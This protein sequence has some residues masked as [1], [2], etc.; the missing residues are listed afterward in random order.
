[1]A[2]RSHRHAGLVPD[3]P[4]L[5]ESSRKAISFR[6]ISHWMQCC[7]ALP[8]PLFRS[9]CAFS[10]SRSLSLSFYLTLSIFLFVTCSRTI[11]IMNLF[12]CQYQRN[13]STKFSH[14]RINFILAKSQFVNLNLSLSLSSSYLSFF[15]KNAVIHFRRHWLHDYLWAR[16]GEFYHWSLSEGARWERPVQVQRRRRLKR[17]GWRRLEV[18]NGMAQLS[19]VGR[20]DEVVV[21]RLWKVAVIS[22]RAHRVLQLFYE[23]SNSQTWNREST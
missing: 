14:S 10:R 20:R 1:M 3:Y 5:R 9:Q 21:P 8:R 18:D 23:L 11:W 17:A 22:E 4:A 16:T 7:C 13:V 2:N 15:L 6:E 12:I 19:R